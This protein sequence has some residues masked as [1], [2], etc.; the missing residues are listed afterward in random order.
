[1]RMR[2]FAAVALLMAGIAL[3]ACAQRGGGHGGGFSGHAGGGFHVG[4]FG[5]SAPSHF[6]GGGFSAPHFP[7]GGFSA[8]SRFAGG[9]SFRTPSSF[10][11]YSRAGFGASH[12]RPPYNGG[13]RYRRINVWRGGVRSSFFVPAYIGPGYLGYPFYGD[14]DDSGYD[15]SAPN[16]SEAAVNDAPPAYETQ[17]AEGDESLARPAYYDSEAVTPSNPPATPQSE[18]AVTVVFKDGRAPEQIHNYALTRTTL[19]VMDEHHRDIPVDEI[20]LDATEKAN[21]DAGVNFQLPV[22]LR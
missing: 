13:G 11:A 8:P 17:A 14:Y 20:D 3:P 2:R 1:M 22:S 4:G 12:A 18:D 9:P 10:P 7:T 21:R 16:N 6:S 19:Y 5:P 15:D